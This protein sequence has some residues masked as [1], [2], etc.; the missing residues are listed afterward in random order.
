MLN[1]LEILPF[2]KEE[3]YV[4]LHDT[5]FMYIRDR[6]IKKIINYSNNQILCYIRG[7]LILPSYKQNMFSRNIGAIKLSKN[8]EKY[9]MQY[10][11]ALGT[12]WQ[13]LPS[14]RELKVL[15]TF[16]K[17]YYGK[18]YENIFNDAIEKNKIRFVK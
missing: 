2:L 11:L 9:Y 1:W 12:Q 6:V 7:E 15:K 18:K 8:Q 17:K 16:F 3:S 14:E 4:V 10:F 13:Y 5:F